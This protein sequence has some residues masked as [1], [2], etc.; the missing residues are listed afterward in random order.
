VSVVVVHV[1]RALRRKRVGIVLEVVELLLQL[2]N[3]LLHGG[4]ALK[5]VLAVVAEKSNK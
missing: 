4:V 3:T 2:R 1:G 5:G